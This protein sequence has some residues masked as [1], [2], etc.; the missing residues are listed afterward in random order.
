MSYLQQQ[1]NVLKFDKRLLEINL[2]SGTI[3]EADYTNHLAKLTDVQNN[4]EQIN[5]ESDKS[6]QDPEKTMNGNTPGESQPIANI[7][8]FGSGY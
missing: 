5:L 6:V 7:D 3:T 1:M 4:S 2:K 8:P